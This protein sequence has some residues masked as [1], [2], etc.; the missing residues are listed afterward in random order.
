MN[1]SYKTTLLSGSL[2][3]A[4]ILLLIN[5]FSESKQGQNQDASLQISNLS[6]QIELLTQSLNQVNGR[7]STL[8]TKVFTSNSN[9]GNSETYADSQSE[10]L[11][12]LES[13]ED[14]KEKND[15]LNKKRIIAF[16]E[17]LDEEQVNAEWAA[18]SEQLIESVLVK[19]TSDVSEVPVDCK[20]TLCRLEVF[21]D[22]KNEASKWLQTMALS[23]GHRLPN[24]NTLYSTED[25]GQ[26]KV[27]VFLSVASENAFR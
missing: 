21:F 15:D 18:D 5:P 14:A 10:G 25:D 23:T 17:R 7:I 4:L 16:Q 13:F 11:S 12:T 24:M 26:T 8:E 19:L 2:I 20:S 3:L 22:E 27:I 9:S 6:R 1:N